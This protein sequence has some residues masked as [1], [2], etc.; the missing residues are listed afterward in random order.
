MQSDGEAAG[1]PFHLYLSHC[2]AVAQTMVCL[3]LSLDVLTQ[4]AKLDRS[5][6]YL[7]IR[8]SCQE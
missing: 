6:F 5:F 4:L 1:L 8:G 2:V 3:V 7:V